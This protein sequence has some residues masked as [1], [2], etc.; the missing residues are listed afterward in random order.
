[1]F[2]VRADESSPDDLGHESG[3]TT[4]STIV[5]EL[6]RER[7][8]LDIAARLTRMLDLTL[9]AL[10]AE[11]GS[12][13]IVSPDCRM[14]IAAARGLPSE[15]IRSTCMEIGEGISGHVAQTGEGLL[16]RNV[17]S[18]DRFRRQNRERYFTPS[19]VSAPLLVGGAVRGVMNASN[20][21]DRSRFG[22]SEL[23]LTVGVAA[24]IARILSPVEL[25]Q[26][27]GSD[28]LGVPIGTSSSD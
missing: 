21:R 4:A 26:W 16:V 28:G 17:E 7:P 9:G 13:L 27:M 3:G 10:E 23:A 15:V 2:D 22:L 6:E 8:G 20:K 11:V 24:G 18:D 14:R 19:C 5:S 1:M 12:I 25:C